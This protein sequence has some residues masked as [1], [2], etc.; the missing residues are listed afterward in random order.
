MKK[1]SLYLSSIA[2]STL[3][4][5]AA[6]VFSRQ[7]EKAQ[8]ETVT[9]TPF[10]GQIIPIQLCCNGIEFTTT[11]EYQS[12]AYGTFIMEWYKMIPVPSAGL[13]LYSWWSFAS[14]EKVLG[15]AISGGQCFTI[16]SECETPITTTWSVNQMGTTL[17]S[18]I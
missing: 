8:A 1:R 11:G 7:P 15:S 9:I 2:L 18:A 12:V 13:G 3:M 5:L 4:I 14:G 17:L 16:A 10:A 6:I